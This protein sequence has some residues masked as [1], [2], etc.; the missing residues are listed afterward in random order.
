M[1]TTMCVFL[2]DVTIHARGATGERKGRE[3]G[4]RGERMAGMDPRFALQQNS[5]SLNFLLSMCLQALISLH[6]LS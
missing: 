4:G 3:V 5:I 1:T 2:T 6:A